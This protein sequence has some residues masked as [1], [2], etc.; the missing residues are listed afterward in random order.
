MDYP[1]YES[2]IKADVAGALTKGF[3]SQ[4][5]YDVETFWRIFEK[6]HAWGSLDVYIE[7]PAKEYMCDVLL[8]VNDLKS[9]GLLDDTPVYSEYFIFCVEQIPLLQ[10]LVWQN[11]TELM[12]RGAKPS[13]VALLS[14]WCNDFNRFEFKAAEYTQMFESFMTGVKW[15][16]TQP[17]EPRHLLDNLY[18]YG[19]A[20]CAAQLSYPMNSFL[21]ETFKDSS[22]ERA[23]ERYMTIGQHTEQLKGDAW[24][25]LLQANN[26]VYI[27]AV[28]L[29]ALPYPAVWVSRK[30]RSDQAW[31]RYRHEMINAPEYQHVVEWVKGL[32]RKDNVNLALPELA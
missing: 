5:R 4:W 12:M 30:E 31:W 24:R 7:Q 19:L 17:A 3:A 23:V 10:P 22:V 29:F 16:N 25:A 14:N 11:T 28:D 9:M 15:L 20:F 32:R 8:Y 13:S 27:P 1:K 6:S 2:N 18:F 21:V 26:G